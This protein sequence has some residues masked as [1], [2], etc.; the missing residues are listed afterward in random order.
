MGS[1]VINVDF[2]VVAYPMTTKRLKPD[3]QQIF[4]RVLG[5]DKLCELT[6]RF[7]LDIG[8]RRVIVSDIDAIGRNQSIGFGDEARRKYGLC[9][10]IP[11]TGLTSCLRRLALARARAG[12]LRANTIGARRQN[13]NLVQQIWRRVSDLVEKPDWE[14]QRFRRAYCRCR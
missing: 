13:R 8:D 11:V 7:E 2:R 10:I 12:N 3:Q 1:R 5:P 4:L 6:D 14:S 9:G